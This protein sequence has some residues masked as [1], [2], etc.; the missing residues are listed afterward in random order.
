MKLIVA[1]QPAAVT[2]LS[3]GGFW[4]SLEARER[5]GPSISQTFESLA[6]L[7]LVNG[8]GC[9]IDDDG[10]PKS[11]RTET[12]RSC[13]NLQQQVDTG[14]EQ[15]IKRAKSAEKAA[16]DGSAL[17]EQYFKTQ[18]SETRDKVAKFFATIADGCNKNGKQPVSVE[19]TPSA[20]CTLPQTGNM[21]L[22][23]IATNQPGGGSSIQLCRSAFTMHGDR[24][25]NQ[26]RQDRGQCEE[27]LSK[28]G[29]LFVHE[30]SH[31][32]V[33]TGDVIYGKEGCLGLTTNQA[34]KNADSYALFAQDVSAGCAAK[35]GAGKQPPKE[36]NNPP[37][38]G[39]NPPVDGNKPPSDGNKPPSDGNKPPINEINPPVN[40]NNPP[41]NETN[42]PI[43][44]INPPINEIKPPI[45]GNKPPINE[46]NPP[47]NEINPPINGNKP[48]IT[49]N[50]PPIN[51]IN[52]PINGT[53]PPIN[54]NKPPI[55]P[56]INGN[57]PP[58]NEINPPINGTNPPINGGNDMPPNDQDECDANDEDYPPISDGIERPNDQDECDADDDEDYLD[59]QG[60][61]DADDEFDNDED[62]LDN[63]DGGDG[64]EQIGGNGIEKIGGD[65]IDQSGGDGIDQI[66]GNVIK[67]IDGDSI[68]QSG[69][70]DIDQS[71]N[72][73]NLKKQSGG[74]EK[75][76]C[77]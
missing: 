35:P 26:R 31:A 50:K 22:A 53:N 74:D 7:G 10:A 71:G 11:A 60:G 33:S 63:Q 49:G 42:P 40:E 73:D 16:K 36:G 61:D 64:I 12:E 18:D 58:I 8:T 2:A 70:D 21:E 77:N 45:N 48:P 13:T 59:N 72:E 66:V 44:E 3:I 14:L 25:G 5:D 30:M 69:D 4:S 65:G 1:L 52:P 43:N 9:V 68:D 46:I 47:I 28:L 19:C 32:T 56:P 17:F 39:N 54:G 41:I 76:F 57:K 38:N 27:N 67:Q 20:R 6:G 62:Y 34:L 75:N 24:N 55:K 51:E 29:D 23:A 15:C 37:I